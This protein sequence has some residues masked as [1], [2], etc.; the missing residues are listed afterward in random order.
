MVAVE[1]DQGEEL[2]D[3]LQDLGDHHQQQRVETG[4]PPDTHDGH[5]HDRVEIQSAKVRADPAAAAQPVG[6]GDVGEESGPDQVEAGAHRSRRRTATACGGGMAELVEAGG[7][8]GDGQ[9]QQHQDRVGEGVVR[10]GAES[11][12]HQHP[13]AGSEERCA[14]RHDDERIKQHRERG[15]QFPRAVRIGHGVAEA[16]PQQRVGFPDLRLRTVGQPEQSQG[17]ELRADQRA[18]VVRADQPAEAGAGMLCNLVDAA[19][20]V[21]RLEYQVQ[22]AG[23]LDGLPVGTPDQRGRLA[24]AGAL[25]FADQL[26]AVGPEGNVGQINSGP[27]VFRLASGAGRGR[28]RRAVQPGRPAVHCAH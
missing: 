11:L 16:H 27:G 7:Q 18:D 25:C 22:Q 15:G 2:P 10:G 23:E 28:G 6:V 19:V 24:V 5:G 8:N 26:D 14:H 20:A 21:D 13:P 3:H 1:S 17:Q 12:D 4:G 9:D